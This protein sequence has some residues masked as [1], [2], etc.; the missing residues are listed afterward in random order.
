MNHHRTNSYFFYC[1]PFSAGRPKQ[2]ECTTKNDGSKR[3]RKNTLRR[4][5]AYRPN[6]MWKGKK[7]KWLCKEQKRRSKKIDTTSSVNATQ[8][9]HYLN[10]SASDTITICIYSQVKWKLRLYEAKKN[11]L[12]AHYDARSSKCKYIF[13]LQV[14]FLCCVVRPETYNHAPHICVHRCTPTNTRFTFVVGD[15]FLY[16]ILVVQTESKINPS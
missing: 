16:S 5:N 1:S 8:D 3:R 12:C 15:E 4:I 10:R 2:K 13:L 6:R 14:V 9:T 11:I 7:G